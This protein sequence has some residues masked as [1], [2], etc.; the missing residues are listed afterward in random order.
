MGLTFEFDQEGRR[1]VAV[2]LDVGVQVGGQ[3]I[4]EQK[5]LGLDRWV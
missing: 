2:F 4:H 1:C 5:N 3:K